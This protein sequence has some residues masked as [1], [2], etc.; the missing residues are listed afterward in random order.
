[1][2]GRDSGSAGAEIPD[3]AAAGTRIVR[4]RHRFERFGLI[5]QDEL[6]IWAALDR[7]QGWQAAKQMTK[8]S[9]KNNVREFLVF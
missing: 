7:G 3:I 6:G 9:V 1:M 4:S 5:K 2:F 8:F